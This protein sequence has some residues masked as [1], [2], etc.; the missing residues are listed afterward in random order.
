MITARELSRILNDNGGK[1]LDAIPIGE[2]TT[3]LRLLNDYPSVNVMEDKD[4]REAYAA[5][6]GISGAGIDEK[7]LD[8]FFEIFEAHKNRNNRFDFLL[9]CRAIFGA[10]PKKK[11]SSTQ[12]G[13]LT[14]M[15]HTIDSSYYYYNDAIAQI[16][17]FEKPVQ[18][19]LS[20]FE[21]LVVYN[22]FQQHMMETCKVVLEEKMIY[23]LLR[24]FKIKLKTHGDYELPD[25]VK[26]NFLLLH[27]A[28]LRLKKKLI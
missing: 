24:V 11:L 26:L 21:R 17:G 10:N 15:A 9:S 23:D 6:H 1:I 2:I 28:D 8:R 7:F 22:E 16:T 25:H 20:S 13:Y 27:A 5:F 19:K 12:Y 3:Y 4:F 18:S 14:R